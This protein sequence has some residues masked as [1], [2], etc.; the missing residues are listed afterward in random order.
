METNELAHIA[1]LIIVYGFAGLIGVLGGTLLGNIIVAIGNGIKLLW[2]KR[3]R[4]KE[5]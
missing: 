3:H 5:Q 2:L 4:K 1:D